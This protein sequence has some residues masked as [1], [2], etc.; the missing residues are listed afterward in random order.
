MIAISL[1]TGIRA[2]EL[3][4]LKWE[5]FDFDKNTVTIRK[6]KPGKFNMIPFNPKLKGYL[7]PIIK[8]TG[9]IFKYKRVPKKQFKRTL[10]KANLKITWHV[11]RHTYASLLT[12]AGID[13]VTVS[14]LLG[15]SDIKTTMI[16]SHLSDKHKELAVLKADF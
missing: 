2:S 3:M 13:I 6:S 4:R 7:Q 8:E 15:H 9:Q 1:Y 16:Y 11:L 5:D 14:K 10:N 12:M